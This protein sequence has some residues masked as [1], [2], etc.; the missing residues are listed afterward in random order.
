STRWA[1]QAGDRFGPAARPRLVGVQHHHAHLAACLAENGLPGPALGVTWDGAGYGSDGTVW[2][3][4]FL[5]GDAADF[6]RVAHLRP[7]RLP[8]G[9]AA[10]KE[11][12]RVA[13]A[14]LWELYGEAALERTDLA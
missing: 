10:A 14:L 6:E 1:E 5:R 4:E 13:L 9:D 12:R 7:F 2:G 8:G 11:P 3:G